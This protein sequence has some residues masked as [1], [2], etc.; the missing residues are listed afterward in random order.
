MFTLRFDMRV[1]SW[2]APPAALYAAVPEICAWGEEHGALAAVLCE[3]HGSEDGYLPSPLILAPAI[4][5]RTRRLAMNLILIL[6]FYEP[7]RLAE[8]MAV[9]DILSAGRASYTLALGYRP[10]EF[11]HFGLKLGDRGRLVD[12]KIAL[13]RR[14]LAGETVVED[15]RRI[16]VT[17]QPLTPGGPG[18]MWG[19][20]TLAAAR[21]AGRYGLGMLGNANTPGMQEA[22]EE[23]CRQHGHQPGPTMFPGRDTPS[24]TFVADNVD[25][26]WAELG[27]HLLHDV[28]TYAAWNPGDETTAGFTHV[29]TVE[30]LRAKPASHVIIS[31]PEA[32]SQVRAGQVLNLSPLC[33]GLPPEVAWPYLKRVGEV[34]L[35]EALAQRKA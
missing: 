22:Y 6:P 23:A 12:E 13:L 1:P 35:P 8:D 15:G 30:E 24:V 9:L 11:D 32:I 16:T 25:Q 29:N 31:V 17:P 28:R 7:V 26:A 27:E 3:H 34:V 10:E 21:R 20:G 19:G 4:A 2:G 5:A 18:L 14:L 33:G